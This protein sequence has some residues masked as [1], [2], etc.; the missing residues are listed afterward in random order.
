MNVVL[1]L[2]AFWLPGLVFGTAVGLRGW[3][4]AASGPLLSF[5]IVALGVPVL[6]GLGI[7]WNLLD[8][9]L[10]TVVLSAVAYGVAFLVRRFTARR[11]EDWTEGE[12]STDRSVRG[13]VLIGLGVLVGM[14]VG[15][16]TFLRGTHS[17]TNV[18]QG[19][20]APFHGNLVRWI[21]EHGDARPSTVGT[22]ANLPDQSDYFYPDTYHAL[23]ALVFDKGG[24]TMM[25]TLNLAVLAV[26]LSV[27]L[28]VAAMCHAWRMP[29]LGTAA[30]AAVSTW[31]TAFPYDSLWRG[32]LWPYVAGVAMIP[33]MLAISRYLLRPRGIAGPVAIGVGVA[34][35]TGLHTSIVFVIAV[36]F[37]LILLAVVFRFEKMQ[38]RRSAPSL[39]A[40]VV[41]AAVLGV[42][43]VLPSLYNAGGV[44]S[45]FWASEAT[46]SGGFGETVTFSPMSNFPQWWIG[47]PAFAGIVLMVRHRR[48]L[49]MVAAYA[50]FGVLFTFTVS[51]ETPLIHTLTG[52]FYNDH[53][54]IAALVPLAGAVAFGEFVHTVTGWLAGKV[55]G[56]VK[57]R[58]VTVTLLAAVLVGLVVTGLS[59]GGYL[60]RNSSSLAIN[61]GDNG[62]A[63]SKDEEAAYA[64]LAE[65]TQPG[66]RVMNDKSDGSVWMYALAGVTPVEWTYYGAE[67]DTKA[68]YLSL[69]LNEIDKYQ[70]VRDDLTDLHVRYVMQGKGKV[71]PDARPSMAVADLEASPEFRVVF[72]NAGATVY[73]IEG[74]QGVVAAGAASGSDAPHGQ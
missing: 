13:Q 47:L 22:I 55:Q 5:G 37:I 45:A 72:E 43:L 31:F 73:Q 41:L 27:P 69:W 30:A 36:Y 11:H 71:T 60:G 74:Q 21:A 4:L 29:V 64:W 68:G 57:L 10:W 70:Q 63:V 44:T 50:V 24:L 33:A 12:P 2:L 62:P 15:T 20:D 14:V 19:W 46:V 58:P 61:Y 40:T 1:I 39:I 56:R 28:G 18:Q 49:W 8:V 7:R 66:E 48:M 3:T 9:A 54:R 51:L 42:P 67:P 25:P 38:W 32:P 6:G 16:A 35:L 65:H 26:I 53:W 17:I 52:I 34:G 59:R 23:L